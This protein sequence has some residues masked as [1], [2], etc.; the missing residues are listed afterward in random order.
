MKPAGGVLVPC[1]AGGSLWKTHI[2]VV[3]LTCR[4][5]R[6]ECCSQCSMGMEVMRW[7]SMLEKIS[8]IFWLG[9][10]GLKQKSTRKP[11][12]K[13]FYKSMKKSVRNNMQKRLD[14]HHVLFF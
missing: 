8:M 3:L 4:A 14:V 10:H 13:H 9:K 7:Q 11:Y 5:I 2:Y 6:K 1:K 12:N